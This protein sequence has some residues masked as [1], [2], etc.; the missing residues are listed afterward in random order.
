MGDNFFKGDVPVY[1]TL[2]AV[3]QSVEVQV[4]ANPSPSVGTW[5]WEVV[6]AGS[7]AYAFLNSSGAQNDAATWH[8]DAPA[9]TYDL[10]YLY[11][12]SPHEAIHTINIDGSSIG[13]TVDAYVAS[14][15]AAL[16][17]V[18][19]ITITGTGDHTFQVVAATKNASSDK[20][21]MQPARVILTRRS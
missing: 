6:P 3:G 18:T 13:T 4:A 5:T 15:L 20:Y 19:G 17:R 14:G 7:I 21:Q 8:F 9:G 2:L 11:W 12:K 10:T 16:T 1:K